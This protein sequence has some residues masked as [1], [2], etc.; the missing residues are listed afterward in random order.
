[1]SFYGSYGRFN[2]LVS[3]VAL[4]IIL[5]AIISYTTNQSKKLILN[6]LGTFGIVQAIIG[7]LQYY[8]VGFVSYSSN[9]GFLIGT[10]A[11]PNFF[12]AFVGVAASVLMQWLVMTKNIIL[13]LVVFLM[14][15]LELTV[16]IL[17]NS[18]QGLIIFLLAGSIHIAIKMRRFRI[19][20]VYVSALSVSILL[21]FLG[22]INKGIMAPYLY[23]F[24]TS[25]R[26]DYFRAAFNMFIDNPLFGVGLDNFGNYYFKYRD[27]VASDRG[28][29]EYAGVSYAHN[30]L[31]QFAATGGISLALPYIF[32][33]IIILW[34]VL[35][36]LRRIVFNKED[37]EV[38][39]LTTIILFLQFVVISMVSVEKLTLLTWKVVIIGMLV[40]FLFL[41]NFKV[42]SEYLSEVMVMKFALGILI[43]VVT[44]LAYLKPLI[45]AEMDMRFSTQ[46]KFSVLN[47]QTK[48]KILSKMERATSLRPKET[49]YWVRSGIRLYSLGEI[50]LSKKFLEK[51]VETDPNFPFAL[52]MMYTFY[53]L[54][55]MREEEKI[56]RLQ[57]KVVNP[58]HK[59]N[60]A[61]L[62]EIG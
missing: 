36:I 62:V 45:S 48:S 31:L 38:E 2:G 21:G 30:E 8:S 59:E 42:I 51:A 19:F 26:G 1:V 60:N 28:G 55:G 46:T 53:F 61:R 54:E 57:Y 25:L 11:N 56:T 27:V 41:K 18:L 47:E 17:S 3:Y 37:I 24:S 4:L 29:S 43:F 23:Q 7:I 49:M 22:I 9:D 5:L 58:F 13:K 16:I 34:K 6:V 39:N 14:L 44:V 32:L 12:S 40:N 15:A 35:R 33:L 10:L 52:E 50:A 20:Y